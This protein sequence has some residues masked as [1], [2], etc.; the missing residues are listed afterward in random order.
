MVGLVF[1]ILLGVAAI[2][3]VVGMIGPTS[4]ALQSLIHDVLWPVAANIIYWIALATPVIVVVLPLIV[5]KNRD[6]KALAFAGIYGLLVVF[7]FS[8][9]GL[10]SAIAEAM[11]HT[12]FYSSWWSGLTNVAMAVFGYAAGALAWLIDH[13]LIP[14]TGTINDWLKRL[15]QWLK[16]WRR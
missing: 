15:A 6:L 9:L 3:G 13:A 16:R 14:I 2:L 5:L 10:F 4:D 8:Q 12:L 7:I 1:A 11:E